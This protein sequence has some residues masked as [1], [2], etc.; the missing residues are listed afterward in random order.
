ME[1]VADQD[2]K[3]P[4]KKGKVIAIVALVVVVIIVGLGV[5]YY[6]FNWKDG[7]SEGIAKVLPYPAAI[8]DWR[9]VMMNLYYKNIDALEKF[10]ESQ[11]AAGLFYEP[12]FDNPENLKK[13]VLGR[14]IEER[15]IKNLVNKYN[16]DIT[17][18][19][20]EEE[21]VKVTNLSGSQE[22]ATQS[23]AELY[24]WTVEDFKQLAVQEIVAKN[25]LMEK[26]LEDENIDK[27][28]KEQALGEKNAMAD[29]IL[30]ELEG[31]KDF[32]KLAKEKSE[33]YLS[34]ENGGNI[35]FFVRGEM[36]APFEDAAFNLEVG[37][38]SDVVETEY[39][40]HIIKVEEKDGEMVRASHI[41]FRTDYLF[42]EWLADQMK[43]AMVWIPLRGITWNKN[44]G[45]IDGMTAI[46]ESS[47]ETQTIE[48]PE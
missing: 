23:I 6:A 36:V 15:V 2:I 30:A 7:V 48:Q 18:E 9:F 35:G 4:S 17:E 13:L 44:L 22:E 8:V 1:E 14:L 16:V 28:V 34:A 3:K 37:E 27:A 39:G 11:K 47:I 19:D 42:T 31:G 21:F 25:K 10:N 40:Y 46:T 45:E 29:E 38:I 24:G 43:D 20:I 5:G 33:D 32:S 26:Y 41:L 12:N